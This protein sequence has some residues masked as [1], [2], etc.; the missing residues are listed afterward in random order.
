MASGEAPLGE[1]EV[2]G[3]QSLSSDTYL[4][5]LLE[6]LQNLRS[7]NALCDVVLEAEGASFAAHRAIL[8]VASSYCKTHF[9]R[10]AAGRATPLKLAP[11][12]TARGLQGI[13]S[14]L[15][16]NRLELTLQTVEEVFRAAEVLLVREVMRLSF[17]FLEGALDRHTCLPILRLARRLGPEGLRLKVQRWVG[18][19]CGH[20][21]KDPAQLKE[22][23]RA[24]LCEMLD[25][26]DT[27]G[28]S[29]LQLFQAAVCWLEHN[30]SRQEDAA[31]VL[32]HIRFPSIPLPDLQRFVQETPV[33]R[34]EPACRRYL[35][36]ALD[37]HSQPYV[38][39]LLHS[40][41]SRVRH[42]NE[43]LM[44]LGGRSADN[45]VCG[46]VWAADRHCH[47]WM[48]IGKLSGP[49]YN[50]C[51]AVLHDF[52]FVMGGQESFDP[53]GQEPSKKVFRFDPCHKTWLQLASM[54][55]P[56]TRFYAGALNERL[57]AVGG[58]APLGMPTDT[59][60]EYRL[61]KNAW[62]PL[63]AFPVP[64]A[65]HAG[66]TH[67]GLLYISG[68]EGSP[69]GQRLATLGLGQPPSQ[70][71]KEPRPVSFGTGGFAEGQTLS[72]M[73][74]YLSRLRCWVRNR[75]M[76][77]AR[78]DHGMATVGDRIFCLGGRARASV[79]GICSV[80]LWA[81]DS[82]RLSRVSLAVPSGT[83]L[84]FGS[85]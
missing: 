62:R 51:V 12:V 54:L 39:P 21:L 47:S 53:T 69:P 28:L 8:A 60:E 56:R 3:G 49:L 20:L 27:Q 31:E 36:E 78:C 76:A 16:S 33:M 73:Y 1:R 38:Q 55:V 83:A 7:Q 11:P 18:K 67:G 26:G 5:K 2:A 34:T 74:S 9:A 44:V 46:D 57:V 22:L 24:T 71:L 41:G 82:P 13:L 77:F 64:V 32:G 59:A 40:E 65:D 70:A 63:P 84:S 72:T 14:F 19:H 15:Y 48:A 25:G 52:V 6:G 75:P 29:E 61:A 80:P 17:R 50:H 10:E 23:D 4:P 42:R 85:L 35:Q 79:G 30:G 68:G 81:R 45:A 37:Y 43:A 66:A 58:G